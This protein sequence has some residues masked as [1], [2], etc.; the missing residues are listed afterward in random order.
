M[1]ALDQ[2]HSAR[3]PA[4]WTASHVRDRLV[5]AFTVERK[6]PGQHFI[7]VASSWP[8]T[9]VHEFHEICGWDD[10]RERV[11]QSWENA[12]GAFPWEVSRMD[13]AFDWLRYLPE[14]ERRCL[15][16]WVAAKVRGVPVRKVLRKHGGWSAATFYRQ[17][18]RGALRIA[19]RLNQQGVQVR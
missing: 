15:T 11:W 4:T 3:A 16:A 14:G 1:N 19:E 2:Q 17:I 7:A 8:A 9:P 5:E 18:N 10:A 12:S 13:Q 6:L